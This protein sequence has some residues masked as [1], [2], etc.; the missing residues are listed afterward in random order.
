[1][2]YLPVLLLIA[3][4]AS[5]PPANSIYDEAARN[6]QAFGLAVGDPR[7]YDCMRSEVQSLRANDTARAGMAMQFLMN[8]PRQNYQPVPFTPMQTP[9][10]QPAPR[11]CFWVGSV[12]TC[13]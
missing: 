11:Q 5:T 10:V 4:C 9:Q 13:Q 1:M 6:C 7:F 8:Q 12:W 2:R 3:G